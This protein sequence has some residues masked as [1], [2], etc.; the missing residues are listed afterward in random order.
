LAFDL[1]HPPSN[2]L[3]FRRGKIRTWIEVPSSHRGPMAGHLV[4][5]VVEPRDFYDDVEER[6]LPAL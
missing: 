3:T 4:T 6:L 5:V 1:R 2:P